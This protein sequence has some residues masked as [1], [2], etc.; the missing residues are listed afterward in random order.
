MEIVITVDY[1]EIPASVSVLRIEIQSL[2]TKRIR[3][4]DRRGRLLTDTASIVLYSTPVTLAAL[5]YV[6]HTCASVYEDQI[7]RL[8]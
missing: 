6:Y 5:V 8:A 2:S 7:I 4:R 3:A 1:R